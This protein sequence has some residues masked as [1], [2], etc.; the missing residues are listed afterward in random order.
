MGK[1]PQQ[2]F[3]CALPLPPSPTDL[4]QFPCLAPK[5]DAAGIKKGDV[6]RGVNRHG[7]VS[8][9]A[10]YRDSIGIILKLTGA[11]R[12]PV[13]SLIAPQK[14]IYREMPKRI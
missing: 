7:H 1:A 10:L 14:L 4:R 6:F 5:L 13:K 9:R 3:E 12:S 11:T 2:V 8:K